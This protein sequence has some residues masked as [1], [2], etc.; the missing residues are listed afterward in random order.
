VLWV[1]NRQVRSTQGALSGISTIHFARWAIIDK[2]TRLLFESNYDG[3]WESY[4][5][6]FVDH[7]SVGLNSI[8][9]NCLRYPPGGARDIE[10]FKQSI[11]AN[12]IPAQVFYSA[13]RELSVVNIMN[14]LRVADAIEQSDLNTLAR[15][16]MGEI[17]FPI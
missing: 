11:R 16:A 13:Y 12:Q 5:D 6:D 3:S 10:A 1:A 2:G 7:V 14:N 15:F 9:G 8:W 17:S 4:I